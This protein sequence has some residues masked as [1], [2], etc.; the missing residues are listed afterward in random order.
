[1]SMGFLVEEK[2]AIVWRGPMVMS[3]IEKLVRQVGTVYELAQFLS[4]EFNS[5]YGQTEILKICLLSVRD[6]A[7]W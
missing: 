2:A 6:V 3:A 4:N 7:P 5:W 1:M